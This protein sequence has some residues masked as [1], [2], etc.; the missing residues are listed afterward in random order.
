M[1]NPSENNAAMIH[2]QQM[3]QQLRANYLAELPDRINELE[4]RALSLKRTEGFAQ[5]YEELYRKIHSLKG[6]AGTYGLQIVSTICHQMEDS[7]AYIANDSSKVDDNFLDRCIEY[8][9]LMRLA[10]K[11]AVQGKTAFPEVEAALAAMRAAVADRRLT[12]LLVEASRVNTALYLGMLKSL[13]VQFSIVNSGYEALGLLLHSH[14]DLLIT[15]HETPS[16]NGVALIAAIRLNQ[17]VNK[18]IHAILLTSSSNL[19]VPSEAQPVTT[20]IRDGSAGAELFRE[21]QS[22]LREH[23]EVK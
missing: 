16:L 5:E 21:V 9:D 18:D 20:I 2:A 13:P 6:G 23:G 8:F 10:I 14:F 4:Q 1:S 7:L 3:M 15:G 19:S 17:G 11:G 12:A 22:Y